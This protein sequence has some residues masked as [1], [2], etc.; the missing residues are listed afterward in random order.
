VGS[1][2]A[3]ILSKLSQEWASL[4]RIAKSSRCGI[5]TAKRWLDEFV[6]DGIADHDGESYRLNR[7]ATKT[8]RAKAEKLQ[9]DLNVLE[10]ER[11]QTELRWDGDLSKTV[12]LEWRNNPSLVKYF[13]HSMKKFDD[14]KKVWEKELEEIRMELRKLEESS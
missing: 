11:G 5:K 2:K 14:T 8:L 6:G 1:K 13:R 9:E 3:D 10:K 12:G 4:A 7:N